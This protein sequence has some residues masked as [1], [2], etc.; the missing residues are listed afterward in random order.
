MADAIAPKGANPSLKGTL[1]PNYS[2]VAYGLTTDVDYGFFPNYSEAYGSTEWR[3]AIEIGGTANGSENN[4]VYYTIYSDRATQGYGGTNLAVAWGITT[5]TGVDSSILETVNRLPGMDGV[6]PHST[7]SNAMGWLLSNGY[8]V[9]NKNYPKIEFS[10]TSLKYAFDPTFMASYPW[11]SNQLYELTGNAGN[12]NGILTGDCVSTVDTGNGN[13]PYIRVDATPSNEGF[14]LLPQSM[15]DGMSSVYGIT[16]S[17]WFKVDSVT[18]T[19]DQCLL[20]V[21]DTTY[22]NWIRIFIDTS[23]K[24]KFEGDLRGT[25]TPSTQVSLADGFSPTVYYLATVS[26]DLTNDNLR[27][28]LSSTSNFGIST[29]NN[30]YSYGGTTGDPSYNTSSGAVSLGARVN[31]SYPGSVY[32]GQGTDGNFGSL[33][34]H[35]DSSAYSFNLDM[36]TK[37]WNETKVYY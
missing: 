31:G 19:N 35:V 16:L 9:A 28:W 33:Y 37:I 7:F 1:I 36:A 26:I 2:T 20:S 3:N 18:A 5:N 10:E 11:T 13:T 22:N 30:S 34:V 25:G 15:L 24:L 8:F 21:Y 14:L 4:T 27:S 23:G 17:F 32:S 12:D 6:T 29:Y